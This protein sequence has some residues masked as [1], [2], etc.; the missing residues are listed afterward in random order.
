[1]IEDFLKIILP[2]I[3]AGISNLLSSGDADEAAL[4]TAEKLQDDLAKRRFTNYR[5]K[6]PGP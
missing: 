4:V 2:S 6:A 1:M 5:D 3:I